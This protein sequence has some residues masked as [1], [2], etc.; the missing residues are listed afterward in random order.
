MAKY[1]CVCGKSLGFLADKINLADGCLCRKCLKAG[2]M[3]SLSH[4]DKLY[5]AKVIEVI[6]SRVDAVRNFRATKSHGPLKIDINSQSFMLDG[7]FYLFDNLL[8]YT[9]HEDPDN[10]KHAV[11][12]GKSGGATIGGVIGGLGGG[13]FAGAIGA[14]VGGTI[15]SLLTSTCNYM[16][17]SV[18][19]KDALE[20][21]IRLD[22]IS[23]KTKVSSDEYKH[24]LKDARDCLD[25]LQVIA[26]YNASKRQEAIDEKKRSSKREVFIQNK[27]L[28]AAELADELHILKTLLYN[29]DITQEEFNRK[30]KQLLDMM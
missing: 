12:N 7:N 28:T 5:T 21:D 23:E 29:D 14:A 26:N 11:Q 16:Y 1:C 6:K 15:G 3:S 13:L 24:A 9:Y 22:F 17:I 10:S 27:H 20:S 19:L 18:T 8:S 4:S 2:G 25:G 30:K